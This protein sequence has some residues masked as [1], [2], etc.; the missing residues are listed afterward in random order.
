MLQIAR[1]EFIPPDDCEKQTVNKKPD[2]TE[3][4]TMPVLYK[5]ATISGTKDE[6]LFCD[7]LLYW[8]HLIRNSIDKS[9]FSSYQNVIERHIIPYFQPKNYTLAD[10]EKNPIYIQEYYTYELKERKVSTNTVIHRHANIRSALEYAFQVG[11]LLSNPADRVIR[12][13]KNIFVSAIY[14][15]EEL[16]NLF[17]IFHGDPL[18]LAVLLGSYYGLRR[19]EI[20]GLKWEAI[21]FVHKTITI[22]HTV[23]QAMVDG[24][25]TMIYKDR[26]KTKKSL[27]TL[28][29]VG[30][31]EEI[32]SQLWELRAE[33]QK[34]CGSSYCMDFTD[35][36][37]V[38]SM[39]VL[40][41]P[42]YITLHFKRILKKHD[43]KLIRFHDLRHS[44]AS[45][46][47]ASGVSI[48]DIQEWLGHSDISTT[49]NIYTHLD[50][51]NKVSS[52]NAIIGILPVE[53][54]KE[55]SPA[56]N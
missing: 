19:S 5:E 54:E 42:D 16:M 52:A 47:Y 46:L 43:L 8:L 48:K 13:K 9:T 29:L 37:Y 18:E 4:F 38:N 51:R 28:P 2:N 3:D 33:N 10:I 45:L 24:K 50:Y 20:V 35:Y 41:K 1:Q 49:L 27:R 36:V 55:L 7:F 53:N 11:L 44:C 34:L 31:F 26:P 14:H 32:F 21:D 22:R 6:I 39:G 17:K 12:P 15:S 56:T 40:I 30:P 25:Y 23:T